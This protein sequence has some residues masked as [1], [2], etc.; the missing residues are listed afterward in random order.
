MNKSA[1]F[2]DIDGTLWDYEQKIIPSTVEAV[3]KLR[4]AGHMAF[5]CSGRSRSAITAKELLDIGFDGIVGGCG[6]YFEYLGDIVYSDEIAWDRLKKDADFFRAHD[7]CAILEGVDYLYVDTKLF[8]EDDKYIESLKAQLSDTFR[9]FED[10]NQD[11]RVN[12]YSVDFRNSSESVI[13]DHFTDYN[14]VVHAKSTVAEIMPGKEV[15]KATGIKR[16]IE[17]L[18]IDYDNTYSFGD[19]FN[20]IDMIKYTAHSVAM[21]N[22]VSYI[23]EISEYVTTHVNEDGIYNGLEHFGLI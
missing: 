18:G 19:S 1:V 16:A 20:D 9:E 10:L 14:I 7:I 5:L 3:R 17:H 22:A 15:S 8:P 12:K 23:K 6:T 2:F 4:A 11:S 13:R 21:G